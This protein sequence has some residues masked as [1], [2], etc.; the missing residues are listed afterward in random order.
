MANSI[1]NLNDNIIIQKALEAFKAG[2]LPITTFATNFSDEIVSKRGEKIT[3]PYVPAQDAAQDFNGTYDMQDADASGIEVP[4]NKHKFVSWGLTDKE[5]ANSSVLSLELFGAQKGFQLAKAVVQDILSLVTAANYGA[6]VFTGLASTFDADDVVDI[7]VACDNASIP[8]S[9]RNMVLNPNYYGALLKDNAI[10][11]TSLFGSSE[12]V[13]AG[14]I[15]QIDGFNLAKCP[16]I[17]ANGENL[18]GFVA[19]PSA[20]AIVMRYL[21][22]QEGNKYSQ[23]ISVVDPETKITLGFREWYSEDTGTKKKIIECNYGFS[24]CE[25]AAL[26]RMVSA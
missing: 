2:L 10:Q 18:V 11:S 21:A 5:I 9:P 15:S 22:P 25:A 8:E 12:P 1:T 23:A 6:A 19:Y 17:P 26:K 3:V 24:K 13:Q 14:R 20:I 7:G 4:I 16:T